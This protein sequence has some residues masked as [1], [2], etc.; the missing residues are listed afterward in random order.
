MDRIENILISVGISE[1]TRLTAH[2]LFSALN[3]I[4]VTY[5]RYPDREASEISRHT[6]RLAKLV[7]CLF[8]NTKTI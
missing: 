3:G 4:M 8:E 1:E 2:A 5:A 7:A 6:L